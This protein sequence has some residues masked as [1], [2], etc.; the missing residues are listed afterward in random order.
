[1]YFKSC[2]RMRKWIRAAQKAILY[3][4]GI[5]NC[6]ILSTK[7]RK[8]VDFFEKMRIIQTCMDT[9]KECTIPECGTVPDLKEKKI[10][11]GVKQIRKSLLKGNAKCVYLAKDADPAITEMLLQL[12]SEQGIAACWCASMA[13]LGSACGI[14]VKAS[15]AAVLRE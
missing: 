2:R 15:A 4:Y 12:C 7:S 8:F 3:L 6:E 5:A 9:I 13:E 10:V 11:A 14:D 1:M